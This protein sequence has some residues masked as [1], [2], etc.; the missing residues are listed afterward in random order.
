MS[1]VSWL[2]SKI[3]SFRSAPME[4]KA[5]RWMCSRPTPSNVKVDVR[6][7]LNASVWMTLMFE[8]PSMRTYTR[9]TRKHGQSEVYY[10]VGLHTHIKQL[11]IS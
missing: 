2:L 1:S 8:L 7:P 5:F 4:E 11:P 3:S 10:T 9:T 6:M